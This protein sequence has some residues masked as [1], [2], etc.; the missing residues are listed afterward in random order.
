MQ[1]AAA[2]DALL[3]NLNAEQRAAASHGRG[4]LLIVAGAGTGKTTTLAHRVAA[5]IAG[6]VDPGR[7]L[8]LTF[9]RRAAAEMLRRVEH[10]LAGTER[11]A[12][13]GRLGP[14][15]RRIWGGTFHAVATR[16]LRLHGRSLGLSQEFTILDRS[17]SEDLL[18]SVRA[19]Q[20]LPES[21]TRFPL[22][23]T[24]LDIYS[25]CVNCREP[26]SKVVAE[27][28]PWCGEHIDA[29]KQLFA[30]YVD[31]KEAESVL[32]YDDLLL[33]W[34]AL[35]STP[36]TAAPI[37]ARFDAVLVDEYQDTNT[38]QADIL[39]GLAP[40]GQGM[41]V[42]GDDAQSIYSF[43]AATVRN[44]LDFPAQFPG[45]TVVTLEQNYRSTQPILDAA[46]DVLA[47]ASEGFRKNLWST[48]KDGLL[49]ELVHCQDETEQTQFIVDQIL[50][51]REAGTPLRKQA[52]LFRA[53]SHSLDIE[54]ELARRNI[55]FHKYGGLKFL[56]TAHVKDLL[57]YLRLAENPRDSVAGSRAL[58]LIPGIGPKKA[59]Q[60]MEKLTAAKSDF[61]TWK[62]YA[63]PAQGT[64]IWSPFVDLML[65]L[66]APDAKAGTI[67]A[68]VHRVRQFY[69]PLLERRHDH[70]QARLRDLEQLEVVAGRFEDRTTFLADLTLDPPS[71]TQDLPADPLLDE[72]YLILSTIHSAKGLEWDSVYVLH[73]ADGCIPSDMATGS[74]S[75]IDEERRLFYVALTRARNRLFVCYPQR[76]YF[77]N[78]RRGD[79]YGFAKRTRFVPDC[80][81]ERFQERLAIERD[82]LVQK[83]IEAA[84]TRISSADVRKQ[85]KQIFQ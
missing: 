23:G 76:Y 21:E 17:D 54:L 77:A 25:R 52:I 31:R 37:R 67:T 5:L 7:V 45:T 81:L 79:E 8:L 78:R 48:R 32:D 73:A 56:E 39:R 6:G 66:A 43:R 28:F 47:Q 38:L 9:T 4:P 68:Q 82:E 14:A 61:R 1:T 64:E 58:M 11:V 42:V 13:N 19:E 70:P 40:D 10:L 33:F 18:Q 72:D 50:Q 12:A 16:L 63:P 49:P 36:E 62:D 57:A 44:I 15:V 59:A 24:C 41:T 46:N 75:E 65:A 27:V 34:H 51:C 3:A 60:L 69:A 20:D 85:L 80:V 22:K 30:V 29:F 2:I 83:I 84:S 71:S 55:P 35:M 26:L 74:E 53:S